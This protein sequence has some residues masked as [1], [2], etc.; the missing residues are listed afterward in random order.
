[1][2][3]EALVNFLIAEF[4]ALHARILS[5]ENA[6]GQRVNYYLLTIGVFVSFVSAQVGRA[7]TDWHHPAGAGAAILA[8]I[9]ILLLRQHVVLAAQVVVLYRRAGRIRCWFDDNYES[10]RRY[11]PWTPGDDTPPFRDSTTYSTYAAR[12]PLLILGTVLSIGLLSTMLLL[13]FRISLT[14]RVVTGIAAVLTSYILV[15]ILIYHWT[16]SLE[17]V[18]MEPYNVHFPYENRLQFPDH[19]GHR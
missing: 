7:L 11:L 1:L 4:N 18:T 16:K 17:R 10:I 3:N 2:T 9:G 14:W 6:R 19:R 5:L 15:E 12:D 8:I 13:S